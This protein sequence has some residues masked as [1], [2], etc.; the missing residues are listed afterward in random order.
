MNIIKV[1]YRK[2][3]KR[4][5]FLCSLIII[6]IPVLLFIGSK[7]DSAI[8]M[9][10][11]TKSRFNTVIISLGFALQ[12][13]IYHLIFSVLSTNL[14]SN[15][16][17]SNYTTLYF[18]HIKDRGALF[19]KKTLVIDSVIVAHSIIYI[20][21]SLIMSY[22]ILNNIKGYSFFDKDTIWYVTTISASLLEFI[23]FVNL[24]LV[25]GLFLKPLQNIFSAITLFIG[26]YLL[27]DIPI[28]GH[29]LP[30]KYIQDLMNMQ[31]KNNINILIKNFVI[32]LV[33]ILIYNIIIQVIGYKKLK[34]YTQ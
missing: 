17:Y 34:E 21:F 26:N 22:L 19:R 11:E 1:E 4:V 2:L 5:E 14:L 3:F 13:G 20:L 9:A 28:I 33:L 12:L 8:A 10:I 23:T 6:I 25:L 18:P 31:Y 29:L 30:M 16:I 27:F 24:I 32:I 15:E 7:N